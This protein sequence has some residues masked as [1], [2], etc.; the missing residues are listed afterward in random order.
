M[1]GVRCDV[2]CTHR[3]LIL[4]GG[5]ITIQCT[6]IDE[7]ALMVDALGESI[8]LRASNKETLMASKM[9]NVH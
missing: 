1:D 2:G 7:I 9:P 3:M 8:T 5:V 4:D 6:V